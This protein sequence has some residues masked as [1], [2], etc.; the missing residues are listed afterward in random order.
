MRVLLILFFCFIGNLLSAQTLEK[1]IEQARESYTKKDYD[2]ALYY[3][4]EGLAQYPDDKALLLIKAH[5]LEELDEPAD[6]YETLS[7]LISAHPSYSLGYLNRGILLVRLQEYEE[8]LKDFEKAVVLA[9]TD[10]LHF[11]S[12]LFRGGVKMHIRDFQGA[13]NDFYT[14]YQKDTLNLIALNSLVLVTNEVGKPEMTFEYL[15]RVLKIDPENLI[16]IT[17][18]G[19]E[20]QEIHRYDSAIYYFNKALKMDSTNALAYSNRGFCYYQLG[21][22]DAALEDV[23]HSLMLYPT[24]SFAFRTKALIL[25]AQGKTQEACQ[26]IE[27]ALLYKFTIMYGNEVE[28]LKK[29]YCQ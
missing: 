23:T 19:F 26:A 25:I 4:M 7:F 14:A 17:N 24:N 3:A 21:K 8:A 22:L 11:E 29:K 10:S 12:I 5:C 27:L 6:S 2:Q 15:N 1:L 9:E 16:A 18:M 13:Y 28:E 20:L